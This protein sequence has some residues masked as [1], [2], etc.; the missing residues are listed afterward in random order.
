[1]PDVIVNLDQGAMYPAENRGMKKE[2]SVKATIAAGNY[3]KRR[4]NDVQMHRHKEVEIVD[5]NE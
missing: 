1:M 2:K 4:F 3:K 5:D